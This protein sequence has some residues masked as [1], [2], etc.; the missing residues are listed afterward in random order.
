MQDVWCKFPTCDPYASRVTQHRS[1]CHLAAAIHGCRVFRNYG[2]TQYSHN[3]TIVEAARSSWATP[4]LFSSIR[5]GH[6]LF[7]EELISAV[8]GFNNPT[9]QAVQEVRGLYGVDRAV[10]TFLSLGAGKRGPVSVY[11]D[12]SLQRI[13]Q[14]T[15]TTE[16]DIERALG[17]SGVYYR[18]SPEHTIDSDTF[19]VESNQFGV[20]VSYTRAYVDSV[21]TRRTIENYLKSSTCT[22]TVD[23]NF[24]GEGEIPMSP[25]RLLEC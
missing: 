19:G 14:Q 21:K 5:V 16:E 11:S 6:P 3:P 22:S 1:I 12:N 13:T 10:S 24:S 17:P 23:L 15:D 4:G 25:T 18:F 9:P 7:P 20:I 8:N 2:S